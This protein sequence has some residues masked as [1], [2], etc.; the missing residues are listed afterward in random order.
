MRGERG[1][2]FDYNARRVRPASPWRTASPLLVTAELL[3]P[4]PAHSDDHAL[5][6][7]R[8]ELYNLWNTMFVGYLHASAKASTR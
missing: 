1:G 2:A 7:K 8:G 4:L 5:P 3:T 6:K